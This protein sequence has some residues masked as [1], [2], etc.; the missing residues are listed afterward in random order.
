LGI[1]ELRGT[2]VQFLEELVHEGALHHLYP[3]GLV[4]IIGELQGHDGGNAIPFR[5]DSL[6]LKIHKSQDHRARRPLILILGGTLF[7]GA[8]ALRQFLHEPIDPFGLL[9]IP[10]EISHLLGLPCQR[11]GVDIGLFHPQCLTVGIERLVPFSLLLVGQALV[12]GALDV[13]GIDGDGLV[14]E[15]ASR[16]VVPFLGVETS[17]LVVANRLQVGLRLLFGGGLL[18]FGLGFC[19]LVLGI[20]HIAL[21]DVRIGT[22]RGLFLDFG[23]QFQGLLRLALLDMDSRETLF[24]DHL[25]RPAFLSQLLEDL[26]RLI[27]FPLLERGMA[28]DGFGLDILRI[29]LHHLVAQDHG[30][31]SLLTL[32]LPFGQLDEHHL[33]GLAASMEMIED[34]EARPENAHGRQNGLGVVAAADP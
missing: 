2:E 14:I 8:V 22:V 25:R 32:Q 21:D 11:G 29:L 20:E 4:E 24:P 27:D 5:E 26:S 6:F 3:L 17:Q 31:L 1:G 10:L 15:L 28:L 19:N 13:V 30:Y 12:G 23:G 34:L 16:F 7:L 9:A 18:V 33:G